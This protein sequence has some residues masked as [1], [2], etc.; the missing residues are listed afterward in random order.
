[1]EHKDHL[2][3]AQRAHRNAVGVV[4]KASR[5]IVIGQCYKFAR[6]FPLSQKDLQDNDG[7]K[8]PAP[9]AVAAAAG[10]TAAA[11]ALANFPSKMDDTADSFAQAVDSALQQ[12]QHAAEHSH[13]AMSLAQNGVLL[14]AIGSTAIAPAS[15]AAGTRAAGSEAAAA[16]GGT[17]AS[18]NNSAGAGDIILPLRSPDA[19]MRQSSVSWPPGGLKESE[20]LKFE[21]PL[22]DYT[23]PE[24]IT[25]LF[26]DLGILT[27]SAVSDELIKLYA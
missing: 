1:V 21:S 23:P 8:T 15:G 13:P 12:Q 5:P 11:A 9:A 7:L 26:T 24:F 2:V 3:I 4:T 14:S 10:N 16:S 25:L 22:C 18:S 17:S 20:L 27:P 19:S 6:L